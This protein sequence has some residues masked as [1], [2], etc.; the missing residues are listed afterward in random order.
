MSRYPKKKRCIEQA[1]PNQKSAQEAVRQGYDRLGIADYY[2]SHSA[3]YRNPHEA[4]LQKLLVGW[5]QSRNLATSSKIID[6]ACGSGEVTSLLQKQGF[7]NISGIDPFTFEAY[8]S[9]TGMVA[10][11]HSFED[12]ADGLV[13]RQETAILPYDLI[14]CSFAMH[15]C[16][17]SRLPLLCL[18]LSRASRE[19]VIFTPHKRPLIHEKWGWRLLEERLQERVRLRSYQSL[20]FVPTDSGSG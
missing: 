8:Q 20:R 6:L 14:I 7:R 15:L 17:P 9:R 10:E 18:E 5:L 4:A 16:A 11:R 12:I 1:E 2:E 19:L 13:F 3:T